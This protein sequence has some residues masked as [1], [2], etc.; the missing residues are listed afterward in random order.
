MVGDVEID[1][2]NRLDFVVTLDHLTQ[3]NISH[4]FQPFVAPAVRPAM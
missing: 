1:A 3:R 2:A 4:E